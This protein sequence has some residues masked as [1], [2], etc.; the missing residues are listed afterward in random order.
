MIDKNKKYNKIPISPKT[1]AGMTLSS[2]DRQYLVR[3]SIVQDEA[4][5]ELLTRVLDIRDKEIC[6]AF[7]EVITTQI[8]P[9]LGRIDNSIDSINSTLKVLKEDVSTLKEDVET[10]KG[11]VELVENA[12]E[13]L[14]QKVFKI[15]KIVDNLELR[16]TRWHICLRMATSIF[17][18][19]ILSL[20]IHSLILSRN[21]SIEL[22][23]QNIEL[24]QQNKEDRADRLIQHN[25]DSL[26]DVN[27]K[28]FN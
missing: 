13:V 9:A 11:K 6:G 1:K 12:S 10:I 16:N 4:F 20:L 26:Y 24:I 5:E 3:M 18:A 15:K 27:N 22:S 7:A 21:N 25:L 19:V 23:N 14:D 2:D 28:K 8:M 17:I